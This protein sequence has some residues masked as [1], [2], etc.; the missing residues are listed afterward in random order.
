MKKLRI[1]AFLMAVVMVAALFAAC[2]GTEP[3]TTTAATTTEATTA[4]T[5][6]APV[7]E[8]TTTEATTTEATTEAPKTYDGYE[9]TIRPRG[10][11]AVFPATDDNGAYVSAE[12]AELAELLE[13]AETELDVKFV[14]VDLGNVLETLTS[15]G[16]SGLKAADLILDHQEVWLPAAKGG[17][18]LPVDGE[19]LVN[20]GLDYSDPTRWYQTTTTDIRVF[21]HYWGVDIASKHTSVQTGYFVMFNHDRVEAAGVS[22]IYQAVRDKQWTW[23]MYLDIARKTT[24]DED[25]DGLNDYW[26]TCATAWGNEAISNGAN[27]VGQDE[28]GRW[29]FT[30][31]TPAGIEAL[32]FLYDMNYGSGTRH[33]ESSRVCRQEFLDGFGTFNWADVSDIDEDT[34]WLRSGNHPFG[35]VPMPLGP[36]A[37]GYVSAHDHLTLFMIQSTN[38]NL[39]RTVDVM[40]RWALAVNDPENYLD[41]LDRGCCNRDEDKE[42]LKDYVIPNTTLCLFKVTTEISDLIDEGVI[43]GV[44]YYQMTPAQAIETYGDQIQ[45]VLDSFFNN[46][47]GSLAN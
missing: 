18:I 17:Y 1:L 22:D 38:D 23:E 42:M 14:S 26:G 28:T 37:T 10:T 12:A 47:S 15:T 31:N 8:A 25:G 33:D 19:A 11:H 34:D 46:R 39:E 41:V 30:M 36:K 3:E 20:A 29:V 9:F 27:Y 5:T 6:E 4:G 24:K 32:Q 7:T 2:S 16:L 43:S 40:N 45:A 44:S 21:D 35:C 13:Q